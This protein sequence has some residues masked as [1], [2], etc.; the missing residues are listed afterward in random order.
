[1]ASAFVS[2][3]KAK[4][5]KITKLYEHNVLREGDNIDHSLSHLN[6]E[7]VLLPENE[8]YRTMVNKEKERIQEEQTMKYIRSDAV[9]GIEAIFNVPDEL[10]TEF[11][12]EQ[13]GEKSKQWLFDVFGEQNV[14][15]M[16]MHYDEP[17]IDHKNPENSRKNIHIHAFIVPIDEK[18]KLNCKAFLDGPGS[19]G[20]LQR[21]YYNEVGKNLGLNPPM[22]K[23]PRYK[24][25]M[26]NFYSVLANSEI[27]SQEEKEK[28]QDC[29]IPLDTEMIAGGVSDHYVDRV[30][31]EISEVYKEATTN[32]KLAAMKEVST[33]QNKSMKSSN[34]YYNKVR[35]V[36]K[37][38]KEQEQEVLEFKTMINATNKS[39]ADIKDSVESMDYLQR[40]FANMENQE[41]AF[42]L[43]RQIMELI[44]NERKKEQ[45]KDKARDRTITE[46]R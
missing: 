19:T 12:Y 36:A 34:I 13:W 11:D 20:K 41:D 46:E 6:K 28:I 37:T 38:Q 25:R 35:D 45:K 32:V 10:E 5:A 40:G 17:H 2:V 39:L 26:S 15:H 1:M 42:E 8:T 23:S 3:E 27:V 44:E 22:E 30:T 31:N 14:K 4:G 18:G 16:I 33:A 24:P 21:N 29:L 43:Q 7:L 9:E